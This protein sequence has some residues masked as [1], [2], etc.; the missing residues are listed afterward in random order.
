[1]PEQTAPKL[2]L[3]SLHRRRSLPV[4]SYRISAIA[5]IMMTATV[6]QFAMR[7]FIPFTFSHLDEYIP[8]LY[9]QLS[10]CNKEHKLSSENIY[11]FQFIHFV[12]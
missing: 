10:L 9:G 5:V 8:E 3:V 11:L 7:S 2:S 6:T 1:M 4:Y 12:L